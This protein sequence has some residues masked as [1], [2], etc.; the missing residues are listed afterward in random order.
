LLLGS[1]NSA[2]RRTQVGPVARISVGP[3]VYGFAP[4][5]PLMRGG[6]GRTPALTGLFRAGRITVGI[7][8][9]NAMA[10]NVLR[11]SGV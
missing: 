11:G 4:G 5:V 8:K 6:V 2:V 1:F 10:T 7:S 3:K 9:I